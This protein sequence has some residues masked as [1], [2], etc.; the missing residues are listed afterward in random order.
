MAGTRRTP[1]NRQAT[2]PVITPHAVELFIELERARRARQRATDCTVSKY[3]HCSAECGA[4]ELWWAAH[5]ELCSELRL[6]PWAWP[7]LPRCPFPPNSDA[8]KTW[9][10]GEQQKKLQDQLEAARRAIN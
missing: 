3:G 9:R 5:G 7:A 10:P 8:A 1:L 2:G 6:P 4:C